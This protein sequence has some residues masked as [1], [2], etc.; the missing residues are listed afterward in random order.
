MYRRKTNVLQN[1]Q[2]KLRI[3][4]FSSISDMYIYTSVNV[5]MY[6]YICRIEVRIMERGV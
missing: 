1:I 6:K 2:F 5:R 4:L 3:D